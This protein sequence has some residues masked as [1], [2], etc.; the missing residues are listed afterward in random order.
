MNY[1]LEKIAKARVKEHHIAITMNARDFALLANQ[2][3]KRL[4]FSEF[5]FG[6]ATIWAIDMYFP[7]SSVPVF[8]HH[9]FEFTDFP[10]GSAL[11]L[12]DGWW[13]E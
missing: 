5:E 3:E 13:S 11:V 2:L 6:K 7:E 4:V 1:D 10:S 9:D 12:L 8:T